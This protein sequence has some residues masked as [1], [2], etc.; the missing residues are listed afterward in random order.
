MENELEIIKI[1]NKSLQQDKHRLK[2]TLFD[3]YN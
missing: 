1:E 3:Q 2:H